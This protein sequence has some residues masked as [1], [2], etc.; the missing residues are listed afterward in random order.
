MV[1]KVV[2]CAAGKGTRMGELSQD[3]PKHLIEVNG[4]PFLAYVLDNLLEAGY[5]DITL[6]VGYQGQSIEEFLKEYKYNVKV[7]NQFEFFNFNEKNGTAVPLMCVKDINEQFLYVSGDNY[8]SAEDLKAIN[9]DDEFSYVSGIENEHPENFGVL[10][11]DGEFLTKIVE[12]PL[13]LGSG[14]AKEFFG[15]LINVSM[16]KFTPE[17]FDKLGQIEK[18]PRG[19]Y[20]ITDAVS[21][22][23]K[24][25]GVKINKINGF[26]MDFGRPE[27]V[28]KLEYFLNGNNK[29]Q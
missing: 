24:E 20:E 23:A 2:I 12:K 4:K 17:I 15:N 6:I 5:K 25:K 19:E 10:V 21:L 13:Q 11:A 1:N 18:S 29:S 14:R 7:I 3:K 16:Y 9:I 22:L 8:Y 27:D 26:W 28:K